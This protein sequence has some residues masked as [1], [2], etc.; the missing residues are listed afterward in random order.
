MEPNARA[1][2]RAQAT[3]AVVRLKPA[4]TT[5]AATGYAPRSA[6]LVFALLLARAAHGL[7]R[8][9]PRQRP[10]VVGLTEM[11]YGIAFVLALAIGYR[12]GL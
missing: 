12:F 9:H 8:F 5:S 3:E 11:A 2:T 10:Q 1:A 6:A 7:S 4:A